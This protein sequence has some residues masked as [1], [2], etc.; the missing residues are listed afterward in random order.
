MG[1]TAGLTYGE[2]KV[3]AG[4]LYGR[5]MVTIGSLSGHKGTPLHLTLVP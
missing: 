1:V 4:S 2:Y 3:T 5:R